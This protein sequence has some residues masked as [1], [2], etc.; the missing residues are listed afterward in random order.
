LVSEPSDSGTSPAA[1]AAP[2]PPDD[3]PV[4]RVVSRGLRLGP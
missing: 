4:M 1:T 3:P 2:D